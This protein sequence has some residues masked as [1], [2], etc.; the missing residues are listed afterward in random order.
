M[1]KEVKVALVHHCHGTKRDREM[2]PAKGGGNLD[3]LAGSTV[4]EREQWIRDAPRDQMNIRVELIK[5]KPRE[6][7]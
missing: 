5:S 6:V 4:L 3:H 2:P 1:E 7:E